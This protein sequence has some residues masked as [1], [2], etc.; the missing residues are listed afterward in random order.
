M[1]F[2]FL[3]AKL[4]FLKKIIVIF[5]ILFFS[6]KKQNSEEINNFYLKK[7]NMR[8]WIRHFKVNYIFELLAA[9]T[10]KTCAYFDFFSHF[11]SFFFS[12]FYP[13]FLEILRINDPTLYCTNSS[14]HRGELI[15]CESQFLVYICIYIIW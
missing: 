9:C 7:L 12:D 8:G 11:L 10:I 6:F 13:S 15:V 4:N 5:F 14:S 1:I 3:F 2:F